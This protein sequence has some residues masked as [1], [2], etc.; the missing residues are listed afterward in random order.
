MH[1]A[2]EYVNPL[3]G[4]A[5]KYIRTVQQGTQLSLSSLVKG[6]VPREG[7]DHGQGGRGLVERHHVP[8]LV[9][10]QEGQ[11]PLGARLARLRSSN[12]PRVVL[13]LAE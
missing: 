1:T 4:P 3:R 13:L 2:V 7:V 11:P 8:S 5:K 12:Q 9:H 6:F 10:T